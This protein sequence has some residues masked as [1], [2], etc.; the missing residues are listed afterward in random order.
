[1]HLYPPV[2]VALFYGHIASV[3]SFS[4]FQGLRMMVDLFPCK[5][6][7]CSKPPSIEIVIK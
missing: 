2:T 3:Q 1:M 5:F 6:A 4:I 7:A